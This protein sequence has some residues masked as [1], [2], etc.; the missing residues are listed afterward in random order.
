MNKIFESEFQKE[1]KSVLRVT[2][3]LYLKATIL[4]IVNVEKTSQASVIDG[5]ARLNINRALV[6]AQCGRVLF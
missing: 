3:V 1:N 4:V 6:R 2:R 5:L